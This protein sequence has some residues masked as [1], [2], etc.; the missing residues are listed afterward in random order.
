M[1]GDRSNRLGQVSD[2]F[3]TGQV[4]SSSTDS[5]PLLRWPGVPV[6]NKDDDT[7]R[8]SCISP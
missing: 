6:S 4:T 2:R 7:L 8:W 3:P 5:T 1:L